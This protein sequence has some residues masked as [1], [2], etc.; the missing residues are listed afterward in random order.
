[1]ITIRSADD[2]DADLLLAWANDPLTRATSFHPHPIDR[3]TH[4]RWFAR[5]L[6]DPATRILIGVRDGVPV[7][8][9]R[10]TRAA[11][12]TVEVGISVA[13]EHRGRGLGRDLLHAALDAARA[14][15]ALNAHRFL[16]RIRPDN[17]ASIALFRGAGFSETGSGSCNG[18]PCLFFERE[19]DGGSQPGTS[20][21]SKSW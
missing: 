16:A 1:V 19:A 13:A 7:G 15:E 18:V 3:E 2:G 14:E 4:V 5:R 21:R 6:A 17:V 8:Q 9:V 20:G 11:D 10:L 12:G